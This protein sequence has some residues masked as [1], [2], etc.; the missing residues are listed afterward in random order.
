MPKCPPLQLVLHSIHPF[1]IFTLEEIFIKKI[2]KNRRQT[3][4]LHFKQP[5]KRQTTRHKK[6]IMTRQMKKHKEKHIETATRTRKRHVHK[7][8]KRNIQIKLNEDVEITAKRN[9][10]G[11][12]DGQINKTI[13][14]NK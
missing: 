1:E 10:K 12:L 13:E 5:I 14:Q 3:R 9:V 11:K 4:E 6:R 7:L 8:V 2:I